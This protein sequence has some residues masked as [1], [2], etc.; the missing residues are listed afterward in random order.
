MNRN[1][2]YGYYH[3]D[4]K[5]LIYERQSPLVYVNDFCLVVWKANGVIKFA[6]VSVA[7]RLK[8]ADSQIIFGYS[9]CS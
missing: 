9:Y 4:C 6:S 7:R 5:Y 2:M 8:T 3:T 1:L